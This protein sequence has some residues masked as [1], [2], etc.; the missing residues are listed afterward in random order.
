QPVFVSGP[1]IS[2]CYVDP[3]DARRLRQP[4]GH[5]VLAAATA[6]HEEIHK[7]VTG[8][9][10]SKGSNNIISVAEMADPCQDHDE[11]LLV[12]GGDHFVIT[13]T[14][15]RLNDRRCSRVGHHIDSVTEREESIGSD[16]CTLERQSGVLGLDCRDA[17]AVDAAH[18]SGAHTQRRALAA[19]YDRIR[20][21][22]FRHP[23]SEHKVG[24]LLLRWLF[25]RRDAQVGN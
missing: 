19:E 24:E 15:A 20:F 5:G 13:H 10:W 17:S 22:E 7:Y 14:A 12:G 4:P 1:R 16:H 6:D 21:D 3:A 25:L 11:A 18:L 23:P 8:E 9:M 2:R